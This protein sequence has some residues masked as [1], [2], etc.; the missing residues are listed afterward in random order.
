M[1]IKAELLSLIRIRDTNNIITKI[2]A[3]VCI[4]D[5][6]YEE[7]ILEGDDLTLVL[8]A[9]DDAEQATIFQSW[10][11]PKLQE[12]AWPVPTTVTEI[13]TPEDLKARYNMPTTIE[14]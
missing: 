12:I 7:F 11:T 10:L 2:A 5:K 13:L 4:N 14:I 1:T 9:K 8:A 3:R 6:Q